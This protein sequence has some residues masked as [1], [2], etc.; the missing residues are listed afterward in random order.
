MNFSQKKQKYYGNNSKQEF[1]Q[2]YKTDKQIKRIKKKAVH[3]YYTKEK[4]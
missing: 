2:K 4:S 3:N 1:C